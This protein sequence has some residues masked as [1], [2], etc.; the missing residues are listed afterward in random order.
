MCELDEKL[1]S[2]SSQTLNFVKI[3]LLLDLLDA[4]WRFI[5]IY[6]DRVKYVML[7]FCLN[8]FDFPCTLSVFEEPQQRLPNLLCCV[9]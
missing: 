5:R 9:S 8:P 6:D 1:K 2:I 3:K 4:I 7:R